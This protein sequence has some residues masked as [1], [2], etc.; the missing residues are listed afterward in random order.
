MSKKLFATTALVALSVSGAALTTFAEADA[1][2]G[3]NTANVT[4]LPGDEEPTTP[5]DPT[6]P[7]GQKGNLTVDNL[8]DF[9]FNDVK[10]ASNEF[11]TGLKDI[12]TGGRDKDNQKRNIQVTDK[13]GT[14][15]GWTLRLAQSKMMSTTVKEGNKSELK[16]AYISIPTVDPEKNV[17]TTADNK[18]AEAKPVTL[19]YKFVEGKYGEPQKFAE[20]AKDNGMGTWVFNTNTSKEDKV[21]LVIPAGNF[22]GTYEGIMTWSV[23]DLD[24]QLPA[25]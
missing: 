3:E 20:A 7:T 5:V 11:R 4:V 24:T 14:G 21:E 9:K 16:G 18:N 2:K 22:T 19:G 15:A 6:D 10:L 8:I 23:V 13:R 25:K 17:Y 12:N 1:T